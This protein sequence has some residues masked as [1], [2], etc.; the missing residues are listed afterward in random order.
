MNLSIR[1][2]MNTA[3]DAAYAGGRRTMA[4]Y[5]N[6]VDV[7]IKS[8][9]TPV[10][11]ADK[12]A[13]E[14]ILAIIHARYPGSDIVAE[15]SGVSGSGNARLKWIIDPLDGTKTFIAG[16]PLYG[17]MIGVEL[18]GKTVAGAV[19]FPAL[20][21]MVHAGL[22]EG[23]YWNGRVA[24]VS[25]VGD[26]SQAMVLTT[27]WLRATRRSTAFESIAKQARIARTWGDCYGHILVATGRADVMFD[28][29]LNPWDC[30]P[31]LPIL[32]EAGGHFVTWRGEPT[33]WGGDGISVNAR[34]LK[35]VLDHIGTIEGPLPASTPGVLSTVV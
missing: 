26:L 14:A 35:P 24:R 8:D 27:D 21:D 2:L 31:L 10:T 12:Q 32:Q 23:C 5:N 13:E 15:E 20:D 25:E 17:A 9:G 18:D 30:S 29:I 22:G 34:L 7:E 1:D 19:Y 33:I 3:A 6:R 16:T 11:L 4:Y 28:P